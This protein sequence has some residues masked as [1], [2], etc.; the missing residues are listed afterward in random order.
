MTNFFDEISILIEIVN[1]LNRFIKKQEC[2]SFLSHKDFFEEILNNLSSNNT[3][4]LKS[5]FDLLI[6]ILDASHSL[7]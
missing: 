3:I 6:N 2:L 4:Y 5:V 1:I 7:K